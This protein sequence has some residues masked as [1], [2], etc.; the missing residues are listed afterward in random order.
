MQWASP[1]IAYP[2]DQAKLPNYV[3]YFY[4]ECTFLLCQ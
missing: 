2:L 1:I 3:E 4:Q